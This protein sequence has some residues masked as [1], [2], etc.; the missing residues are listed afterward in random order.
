MGAIIG[1]SVIRTVQK[2]SECQYEELFDAIA[3]VEEIALYRWTDLGP[4]L[5]KVLA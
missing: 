2:I 1:A 3:G 4:I 5:T